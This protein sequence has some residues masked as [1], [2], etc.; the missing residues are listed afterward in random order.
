ML[1]VFLGNECVNIYVGWQGT[2]MVV[3]TTVGIVALAVGFACT[4]ALYLYAA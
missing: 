3:D 1:A 2:G 4:F